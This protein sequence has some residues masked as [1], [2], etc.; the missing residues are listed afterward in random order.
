MPCSIRAS[1][2]A[3]L[4][5]CATLAL[6]IV[7]GSQ[8]AAPTPDVALRVS[9]WLDVSAGR[10]QGPS[11]VL[12][13]SSRGVITAIVAQDTF[14]QT[15]GV[16]V[17]DLGS[18]TLLP[19]LTDAH[20]HLQIG[21]TPEANAAAILNAGFTTVVD[22]GAFDNSVLH[23]R[24]RI[25]AG[26]VPGPRV[27]AAGLW[28]GTKGGV[29]EFGGI[30]IDG[31]PEGFRQRVRDNI[32]A[33]ADLIKACVSGWPGA[34]LALP[35]SYEIADASLAAL[36]AE[37]HAGKRIVVAH[38]ISRGA[39]RASVAQRVDGLAHAA[40]V[41]AETIRAM[42]EGRMFMIPTLASLLGSTPPEGRAALAAAVKAAHDGGVRLVFGTD[43]G[44]LPHG[45]NARE[46]TALV[47]A[48]LSPIDAIRAATVNAAAAFGL[49]GTGELKAGKA[50]DVIAVS[51]DPLADA[52]A[53]TR[54]VFV[55]KHGRVIK[56]LE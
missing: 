35:D 4:Q 45:R 36:V 15:A 2:S 16:R 17:I 39:V 51:G 27:L 3:G 11:V 18:A 25:A 14:R 13:D 8:P 33:G 34:A 46:F 9:A 44:V 47:A 19:G 20:V 26:T 29:C 22:L 1:C 23:L 56:A 40:F 21:G 54:V 6:W 28:A 53:L 5:A 41:D 55:M 49:D 50:A 42:R 32:G 38:A 12:V 37:A 30:G 43:G 7:A 10:V 31:G 52:S 24:D 48:G